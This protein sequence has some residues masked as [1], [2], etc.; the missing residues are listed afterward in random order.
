M[1]AKISNSSDGMDESSRS[2]L[3]SSDEQLQVLAD[4][5]KITQIQKDRIKELQKDLGSYCDEVEN[6]RNGIE[7][8]IRQNKE[9]LRKNSS[10][11]VLT[12]LNVEKL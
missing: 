4:L 11:Q 3:E 8:L 6:L 10:L 7:R 12:N 9:L 1:R 5:R 2:S